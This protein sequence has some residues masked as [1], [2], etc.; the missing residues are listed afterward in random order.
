MDDSKMNPHTNN[1]PMKGRVRDNAPCDMAAER[2]HQQ[3]SSP[4]GGGGSNKG[5][6]L[7]SAGPTIDAS[8]VNAYMDFIRAQVEYTPIKV[9]VA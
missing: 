3:G 9:V 8:Y 7:D 1:P 2:R 5:K 4:G 6:T